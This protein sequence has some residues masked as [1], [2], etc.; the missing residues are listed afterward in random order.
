MDNQLENELNHEYLKLY[1]VIIQ[2]QNHINIIKNK[3]IITITEYSFYIDNINKISTNLDEMFFKIKNNN[4]KTIIYN[5]N[6]LSS[7]NDADIIYDKKNIT[8]NTLFIPVPKKKFVNY[9]K[10]NQFECFN[11]KLFTDIKASIKHRIME[12]GYINLLESLKL[13]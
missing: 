5:K 6:E 11:N 7:V 2:L 10:N 3:F 9:F 12:M 8:K 1:N 13:I 4:I